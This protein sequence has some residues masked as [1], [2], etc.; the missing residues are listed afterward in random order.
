MVLDEMVRVRSW[1]MFCV[2]GSLWKMEGCAFVRENWGGVGVSRCVAD[3]AERN[4]SAVR[5]VDQTKQPWGDR[6]PCSRVSVVS[7]PA[8]ICFFCSE[9]LFLL[10]C[11]ALNSRADLIWNNWPWRTFRQHY[12]LV[13]DFESFGCTNGNITYFPPPLIWWNISGQGHL[14]S[15]GLSSIFLTFAL[16]VS[17]GL[18]EP[19]MHHSVYLPLF[20]NGAT[21]IAA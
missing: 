17:T 13:K 11:S 20:L 18:S 21:F 6:L 8:A 14:C 19:Q 7:P 9:E 3:A 2:Y 4:G 12:V 1:V 10:K 5:L 15:F 16:C